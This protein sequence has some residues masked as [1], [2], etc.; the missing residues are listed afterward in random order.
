VTDGKLVARPSSSPSQHQYL[1][2][3]LGSVV[4][5]AT[6]SGALANGYRYTYD[7]FGNQTSTP[8]VLRNPRTI[9]ASCGRLRPSL[10]LSQSSKSEAS[11]LSS[12]HL[13]RAGVAAWGMTRRVGPVLLGQE[14]GQ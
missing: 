12:H 8:P 6:T 11:A 14:A 9:T 3:G 10:M 13:G 4:G 7:P 2:D 5:L 1:F